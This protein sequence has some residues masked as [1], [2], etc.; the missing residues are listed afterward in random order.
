VDRIR[1]SGR[2][3]TG[4]WRT[5]NK[6]MMRRMGR[7][8]AGRSAGQLAF[9]P[10]GQRVCGQPGVDHG[11]GGFPEQVVLGRGIEKDQ[12]WEQER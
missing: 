5:L 4:R 11:S 12:E 3:G 9:L 6:T 7:L 8:P 2:S 1:R 10:W